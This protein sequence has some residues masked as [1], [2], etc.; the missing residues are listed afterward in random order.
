MVEPVQ[1]PALSQVPVVVRT[2]PVQVSCAQT[3]PALPL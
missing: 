3:T 2:E 1:A